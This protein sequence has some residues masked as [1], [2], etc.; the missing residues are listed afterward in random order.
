MIETI[1]SALEAIQI[2]LNLSELFPEVS[3]YIEILLTI[4]W[5][6]KLISK[7]VWKIQIN[8]TILNQH[9]YYPKLVLIK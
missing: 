9:I 2:I 6:S 3:K 5:F 8:Y 7:S 4:I 1:N